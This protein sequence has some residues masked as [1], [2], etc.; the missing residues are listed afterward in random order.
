MRFRL[1]AFDDV[2][3]ATLLLFPLT[4]IRVSPIGQLAWPELTRFSNGW[5]TLKC[6][7]GKFF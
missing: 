4:I 2:G 7:L 6:R 5:H 3:F 1:A